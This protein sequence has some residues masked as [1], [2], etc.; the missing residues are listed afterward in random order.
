MY[1]NT[2]TVLASRAAYKYQRVE[3]VLCKHLCEIHVA[4]Q[5]ISSFAIC[6]T[7]IFKQ[8]ASNGGG[9]HIIWVI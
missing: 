4:E 5:L 8:M 2:V 1:L 9:T 6:R 7:D 3:V